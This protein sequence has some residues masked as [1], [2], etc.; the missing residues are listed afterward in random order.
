MYERIEEIPI[1]DRVRY[2]R[3]LSRVNPQWAS[4]RC[5]L[6]LANLM[7]WVPVKHPAGFVAGMSCQEFLEFLSHLLPSFSPEEL[8][9]L[10]EPE[11]AAALL[12]SG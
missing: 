12:K 2:A 11:L 8:Q 3:A 1:F 6:A 5:V 4:K 10:S 9:K 7:E